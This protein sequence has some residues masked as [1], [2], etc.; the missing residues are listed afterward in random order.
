M[1]KVSCAICGVPCTS[2]RGVCK[3]WM[4]DYMVVQTNTY[5]ASH[6]EALGDKLTLNKIIQLAKMKKTSW[7]MELIIE[8]WV[9]VADVKTD[10]Q[11]VETFESKYCVYPVWSWGKWAWVECI[12]CWK[13]RREWRWK[14]CSWWPWVSV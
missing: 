9:D 8:S 1:A 6:P 10:E 12:K 13:P 14:I 7:E 5:I 11:D 3:C 4:K 2:C